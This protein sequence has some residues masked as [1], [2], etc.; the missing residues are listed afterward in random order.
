MLFN[1]IKKVALAALLAAAGTLAL[2]SA[3]AAPK[4]TTATA[5]APGSSALQKA[6]E[7]LLTDALHLRHMARNDIAMALDQKSSAPGKE[8]LQKLGA[9]T[10][11][12]PVK[13]LGWP[14]FFVESVMVL[15]EIQNNAAISAFYHPWSDVFLVL[16]WTNSAN[17]WKV[18]D[19][20]WVTGDW[21][22]QVGDGPTGLQPLWLRDNVK[23]S[24]ALALSVA[25]SVTAFEDIFLA[26]Y[27]VTEWRSLLNLQPAGPGA[28]FNQNIA[29]ARL[30]AVL[31]NQAEFNV[32][33]PK[34]DPI[35]A[36][37]RVT[38]EKTI[39]NL[40]DGRMAEV[41][42]QAKKT[43]AVHR[44][45]LS[46]ID[47]GALE[48]LFPVFYIPANAAKKSQ[49]VLFLLSELHLDFALALHFSPKNDGI[50]AVELIPF[51]AVVKA[52]ADIKGE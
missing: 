51:A 32:P 27:P 19:A 5:V 50:E 28:L 42:S 44:K 25:Q 39:K 40:E 36:A 7:S 4:T 22:R 21:I 10:W 23:R 8:I 26:Q 13:D 41:L 49:G 1:T 29:A 45:A 52:A 46:N 14:H 30:N 38:A 43:E 24:G 11:P 35:P 37:V 17:E 48:A 33:L 16:R 47:P 34:N 6:Q 18:D 12:G 9:S 2:S 15:G 31:M 3:H 20:E